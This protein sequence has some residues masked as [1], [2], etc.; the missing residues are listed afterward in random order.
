MLLHTTRCFIT[1]YLQMKRVNVGFRNIFDTVVLFSAVIQCTSAAVISH[2][3]QLDLT[4]YGNDRYDD[5]LNQANGR[6]SSRPFTLEDVLNQRVADAT[7]LCPRQQVLMYFLT[8]DLNILRSCLREQNS[9]TP[10][11]SS[12]EASEEGS[13]SSDQEER[14]YSSYS[15]R[16]L[17]RILQNMDEGTVRIE[18]PYA[19]S[20]RK[21]SNLSI[22][23]ALTSLADLLRHESPSS[24]P[25][26]KFHSKLL[27]MG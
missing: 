18:E 9:T 10:M 22:H 17:K 7:Q 15:G 13:E 21:R 8:R 11:A 14:Q 4:H 6:D 16:L 24:K 25:V 26:Y 3:P 12:S 2:G 1:L 5:A 20:K 23:S 27:K 19:E